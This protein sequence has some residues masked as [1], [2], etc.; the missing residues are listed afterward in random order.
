MNIING[1]MRMFGQNF[2]HTKT[3]KLVVLLIAAWLAGGCGSFDSRLIGFSLHNDTGET[4]FNPWIKTDKNKYVYGS[5]L[6]VMPFKNRAG[7][8]VNFFEFNRLPEYL[9]V[10]WKYGI[11]ESYIERKIYLNE[12]LGGDYKGNIFVSIL[13]DNSL[14]LSWVSVDE[15][16]GLRVCEGYIF[17]RLKYV[18]EENLRKIKERGWPVSPDFWCSAEAHLDHRTQEYLD[19]LHK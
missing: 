7:G 17:S 16:T 14:G 13:N 5:S 19:D 15:G 11:D 2:N 4:L 6:R 10:G 3:I 1:W 9:V 18:A 8:G 12:S